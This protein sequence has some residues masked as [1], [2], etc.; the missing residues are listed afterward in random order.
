V[1]L[2]FGFYL[3][4]FEPL[5]QRVVQEVERGADDELVGREVGLRAHHVGIHPEPLQPL[6]VAFEPAQEAEAGHLGLNLERPYLIIG[7]EEGHL[8]ARLRAVEFGREAQQV[9]PRMVSDLVSGTLQKRYVADAEPSLA[10]IPPPRYDLV[11]SA[12]TV[13]VV[14]EASRG[15]PHSCT[16][17]ALNIKRTSY[18]M[19]PVDDVIRDLK[20]TS[21]LPWHKRK[22]AMILDNNLGG[23]L[24]NAKALL[25]EVAKLKLWG[26]GAQFGTEC[27]RDHE[28]VELLAKAR[29]RMAFIGMESLNE[30]SLAGVQKNQ[31][32]VEEYKEAFDDLHRHG[33]LTFTGFMF[34]LDED[35]AG[36][37]ETRFCSCPYVALNA[38]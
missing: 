25:R 30:K 3:M 6:V 26:F 34:A 12:F 9:W 38:T 13:P 33:I 24:E 29:C 20:A 17:C 5:G 15:C 31:N 18:R 10:G 8:V 27:L 19:R 21:R 36:Y 1:G 2:F 23:D 4:D 35:T 32:K 16:Y 22:M 28:F 37:Y 14:T 11:E 7:I